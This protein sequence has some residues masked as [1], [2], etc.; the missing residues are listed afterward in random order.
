MCFFVFF[1]VILLY[2]AIKIK[3]Y[4]KLKTKNKKKVIQ[5]LTIDYNQL[6][7]NVVKK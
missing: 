6:T 7:I 2:N 4:D 3:K 5:R 1:F